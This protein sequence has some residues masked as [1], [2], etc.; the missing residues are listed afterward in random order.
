MSN[1]GVRYVDGTGTEVTARLANVY[2]MRNPDKFADKSLTE[3]RKELGWTAIKSHAKHR[4]ALGINRG[5][6]TI[7][8]QL[9]SMAQ[10]FPKLQK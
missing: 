1:E 2:R 10:P 9:A 3:I 6:R 7:N 5:K 8:R 4:Y